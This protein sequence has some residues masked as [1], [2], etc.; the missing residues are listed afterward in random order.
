MKKEL[1]TTINIYRDLNTSADWTESIPIVQ[2]A[3]HIKIN[4]VLSS[5][6]GG[7]GDYNLYFLWSDLPIVNPNGILIPFNNNILASPMMAE[8]S[9]TNPVN[10]NNI[11]FKVAQNG[12][13]AFIANIAN[14]RISI[15]ISFYK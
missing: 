8:H 15:S 1:I 9:L 5:L 2:G 11:Q 10:I 3:K 6:Q 14:G 12:T 7:T 13:G 4:G